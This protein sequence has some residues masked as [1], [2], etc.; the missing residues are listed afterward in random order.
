MWF[1]IVGSPYAAM[2]IIVIPVLWAA[3]LVI[4]AVLPTES[5]DA[6]YFAFGGHVGGERLRPEAVGGAGRAHRVRP[7][8]LL[9]GGGALRVQRDA[10]TG[11]RR[12]AL[13]GRRQISLEHSCQHQRH[14]LSHQLRR[15]GHRRHLLSSGGPLRG[16][17]GGATVPAEGK[18]RLRAM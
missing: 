16:E 9:P 2:L 11:Y 7:N 4:A 14:G 15:G 1:F 6:F 3:A 10:V 8:G 17:V 5:G 12:H 18:L 13:H